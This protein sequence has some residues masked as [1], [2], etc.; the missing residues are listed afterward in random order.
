MKT[1]GEVYWQPE[2]YRLRGRVAAIATPDDPRA[3]IAEYERAIAIARERN[4]KLLELRAAT[5][6]ATLLAKRGDRTHAKEVLTPVH[7]WFTGGFD[8]PDLLEAKV[9]L[10]GLG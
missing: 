7:D 1:T 5:G 2:L 9:V 4:T 10:D 3:A 8:K 6:Y